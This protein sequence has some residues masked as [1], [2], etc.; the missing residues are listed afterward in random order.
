MTVTTA[1][2]R[3]SWQDATGANKTWGFNFKAK[4]ATDLVLDVT[5]TT[6]L[7]TV[8]PSGAFTV[9]FSSDFNSGVVTYPIAGFLPAGYRV[10]VRRSLP[11]TQPSRIGNQGT[12]LPQTYEDALDYVEMQLQEVEEGLVDVN[13]AYTAAGNVPPPTAPQAGYILQALGAASFAWRTLTSAIAAAFGYGTAGQALISNGNGNAPSWGSPLP[14][15]AGNAGKVLGTDGAT[16]SWVSQSAATGG[17]ADQIF[18]QNGQTVNN[19][20]T[21]PA[22]QNA[23][24][25]GPVTIA[26][27]KTVTIPTGQ[28]WVIA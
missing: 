20:Y 11:R 5:D 3:S 4:S 21:L 6:G 10:R 9:A 22:G 19:D 2:S 26:T 28:S 17:G 16:P 25:A 12:F 13:S 14:A 15:Q 8:I 18:L 24:S 7:T 1:T 23:V 27:G